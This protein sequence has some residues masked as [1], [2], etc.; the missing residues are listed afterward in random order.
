MSTDVLSKNNRAQGFRKLSLW[1]GPE[2]L[3]L[4]H[5]WIVIWLQVEE[6]EEKLLQYKAQFIRFDTDGSGDI[7]FMELKYML[8]K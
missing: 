7:D 6:L 3:A 5:H 1:L 4:D 8:E 2:V